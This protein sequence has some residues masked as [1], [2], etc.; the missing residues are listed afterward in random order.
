M[1][2]VYHGGVSSEVV[3]IQNRVLRRLGAANFQVGG[4]AGA[5]FVDV[6]RAESDEEVAGFEGV[7]DGV[8][9]GGEVWEEFRGDVALGFHGIHQSLAGD[10]GDG[11]LGGGIDIGD[12]DDISGLQDFPKIIGERLGAGVAMRLEED[13][14]AGRL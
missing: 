12:E 10:A 2:S 7:A 8:V 1:P 6:A 3:H 5:D 14:E 11:R 9:G 13:D 4:D